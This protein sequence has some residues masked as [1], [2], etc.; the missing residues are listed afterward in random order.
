M[1]IR[2][3][4]ALFRISVIGVRYRRH[5]DQ[6][7]RA[8]FGCDD[9]EADDDPGRLPAADEIVF[10]RT[11]R[12]PEAAA[13]RNQKVFPSTLRFIFNWTDEVERMIAAAK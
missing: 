6:R 1:K 10:D 13:E 2:V 5:P 11:L 9:G 7:Q 4:S 8:G 3:V 12:F